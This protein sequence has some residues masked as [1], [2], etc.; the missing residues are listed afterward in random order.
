M[1]ISMALAESWDAS[2]KLPEMPGFTD[3]L[4]P[5]ASLSLGPHARR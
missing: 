4:G 3:S 1:R 2:A 5:L